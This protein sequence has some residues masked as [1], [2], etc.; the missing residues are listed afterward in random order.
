MRHEKPLRKY[1]IIGAGPSGLVA[2]KTFMQRGILFDCFEREHDIGGIWNFGTPSS[3]VYETTHLLSS[4]DFSGFEDFPIPENY[5]TYLSHRLAMDYFRSYAKNFGLYDHIHFNKEVEHVECQGDVWHVKIAKESEPRFYKGIVLAN[6]HH[7]IPRKPN[8]PGEFTG[9]IIHSRDY[10]HPEQLSGKRIL[11]VGAGNSGSDIAVDAAHHASSVCLS[12]RR[13]HYFAPH[14]TLGW[15]TDDVLDFLEFFPMPRWL[16]TWIY[17]LG[18]YVLVGRYQSL[19]L[20]KPDH[21]LLQA[22]PTVNTE[23]PVHVNHGRITIKPNIEKFEGKHVNFSDGSKEEFDLVVLA[24]GYQISFPFL[25]KNLILENGKP[26]LFMNIFHP[27]LDDLFAVGLIQANGSIWRLAD[28]QSR[29]IASYIVARAR[30]PKCADWFSKLKRESPPGP[31]IKRTFVT[32]DR[33]ILEANYFDYRKALRRLSRKFGKNAKVPLPEP[34][35]LLNEP[36]LS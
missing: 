33:H 31:G 12:M 13:G 2:A 25:D 4:R 3:V 21:L 32:S 14:F 29:L 22:H 6:G 5:P 28:D 35:K 7:D 15:P 1:C 19:G 23:L 11:V 26:K 16:R 18:H 10:K 9:E 24:T 30:D 20:P 17:T 34:H 8:F 27:E 36:S